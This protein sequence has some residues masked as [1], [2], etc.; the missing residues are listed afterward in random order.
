MYPSDLAARV[1]LRLPNDLK[2]FLAR[3]AERNGSSQN[4]EIIRALR[5]RMDRA[6]DRR[7]C[8]SSKA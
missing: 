4:S 7:R 5:E 3:E 1:T 2:V 6:A 8:A